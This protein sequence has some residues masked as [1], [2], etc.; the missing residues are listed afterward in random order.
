LSP[1]LELFPAFNLGRSGNGYGYHYMMGWKLMDGMVIQTEMGT[2]SSNYLQNQRSIFRAA[3]QG[4]FPIFR[5]LDETRAMV[6]W[7]VAQL[8]SVSPTQQT[9]RKFAS[10][11]HGSDLQ[12]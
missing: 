2:F 6:H 12:L 5:I 3:L 11:D 4:I 10:V 9:P 1:K 8:G 7:G